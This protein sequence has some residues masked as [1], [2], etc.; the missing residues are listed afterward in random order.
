MSILKS[1]EGN[2]MY[3]KGC[4]AERARKIGEANKGNVA[5]NKGVPMSPEMKARISATKAAN[6][7]YITCSHCGKTCV[8]KMHKRFHGQNCKSLVLP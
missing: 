8:G 4:T 5:H 6:A 7:V 2:G 1:G 3:G